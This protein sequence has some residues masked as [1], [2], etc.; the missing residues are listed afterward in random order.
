MTGALLRR[1]WLPLATVVL[2]V[3]VLGVPMTRELAAVLL[4]SQTGLTASLADWLVEA[5]LEA[6]FLLGLLV[7]LRPWP[8]R[9]PGSASIVR[10]AVALFL[11]QAVASAP[12]MLAPEAVDGPKRSV[13]FEIT[14]AGESI[15]EPVATSPAMV[16]LA[17][18]Q[19]LVALALILAPAAVV[20]EDRDAISAARRSLTCWR[21]GWRALLA[22]L[23]SLGAVLLALAIVQL[24]WKPDIDLPWPASLDSQS[25][26]ATVLASLFCSGLLLQ[27]RVM[28]EPQPELTAEVFD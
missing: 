16:V 26:V 2:V 1:R 6:V 22:M 15:S 11:L 5:A 24:N 7:V 17:A 23:A 27:I 25:V 18:V 14:E 21:H 20:L 8:V 10:W 9:R 12:L 4:Q 28:T 3:G 19:G 13:T